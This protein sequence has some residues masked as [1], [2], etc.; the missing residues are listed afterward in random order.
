[1]GSIAFGL[2]G[3]LG[4]DAVLVT[5]SF[6]QLSLE[7][8]QLGGWEGSADVSPAV[9]LQAINFALMEGYDIVTQKWLDYYTIETTFPIESGEPRYTL[10]L[11]APGFYKLRHL[12]YTRDAA[13]SS[14]S[15]YI[16]MKPHHIEGAFATSGEQATSGRVPRYRQQGRDLILV[17]TPSSGSVKVY[18]IPVPPQ[19]TDVDDDTLITF[20]VPV[21]V[22]LIVQLAQ[23]EI[24]ERNEMQTAECDR[25]ID[26]LSAM[27][28]TAADSRDAGSPFY[29]SPF[30]RDDDSVLLDEDIY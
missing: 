12:A 21:E 30:V 17:P 11:V 9:L 7:V 27:L 6:A 2:P 23:R 25:K 14:T 28:R 18:Y 5:R 24:L 20:E 13:P 4:G 22:R 8:Q 26:K 3:P 16:P 29:L 10:S 1:M 15:R 19:Y